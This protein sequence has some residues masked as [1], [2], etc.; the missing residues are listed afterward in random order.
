MRRNTSRM[1]TSIYECDDQPLAT[2]DVPMHVDDDSEPNFS[3]DSMPDLDEWVFVPS[4]ISPLRTDDKPSKDDDP[5]SS[6]PGCQSKGAFQLTDRTTIKP[7]G[8]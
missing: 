2:P 1:K 4:P 5:S 3:P 7:A 8:K 6:E